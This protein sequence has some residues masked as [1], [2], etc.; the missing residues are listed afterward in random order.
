MPVRAWYNQ[1]T[2]PG[3]LKSTKEKTVKKWLCLLIS[4]LTFIVGCASLFEKPVY[5]EDAADY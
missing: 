1:G 2:L 5:R 4:I 3:C